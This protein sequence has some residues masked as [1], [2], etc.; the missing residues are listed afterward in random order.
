[1]FF[2][3]VYGIN[4]QQHSKWLYRFFHAIPHKIFCKSKRRKVK[5]NE[6]EEVVNRKEASRNSEKSDEGN[7]RMMTRTASFSMNEE[8]TVRNKIKTCNEK[9][10]AVKQIIANTVRKINKIDHI[11][12]EDQ[13]GTIYSESIK[14]KSSKISS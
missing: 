10:L 5:I 9:P 3:S 1:M 11:R 12:N 2:F 4:A 13:E 8:V 14:E 6:N 7:K